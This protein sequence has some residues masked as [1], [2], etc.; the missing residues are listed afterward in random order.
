VH[1]RA[2][3]PPP[4]TAPFANIPHRYA[5]GMDYV[6]VNG[7]AVV[8]EGVHTGVRSGAVLRGPGWRG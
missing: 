4:H 8:W 6:F 5:A 1:D 7:C 2:T 3:D